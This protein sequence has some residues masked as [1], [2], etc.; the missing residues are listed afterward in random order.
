MMIVLFVALL[1]LA[2]SVASQLPPDTVYLGCGTPFAF[3]QVFTLTSVDISNSVSLR[4]VFQPV[5]LFYVDNDNDNFNEL[6]ELLKFFKLVQFF[7]LIELID[8]DDLSDI[9]RHK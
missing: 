6:L 1:G 2:V 9:H 8:P 7:Q 4:S 5:R 3:Q